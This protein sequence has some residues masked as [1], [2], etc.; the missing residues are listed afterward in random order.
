MFLKRRKVDEWEVSNVIYEFVADLELYSNMLVLYEVSRS[1]DVIIRT[2][3]PGLLIGR[4]GIDIERLKYKL[5]T[6]A[7][8]RR[9]IL[10][11]VHNYIVCSEDGEV[12][13][14]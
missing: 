11:E 8:V 14:Y 4:C 7:N 6:Q 9:V 2:N 13:R 12:E 1:G 5:Q 3:R 10:K